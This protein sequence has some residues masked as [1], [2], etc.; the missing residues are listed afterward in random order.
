[1]QKVS[2]DVKRLVS[3]EDDNEDTTEKYGIIS[4][5]QLRNLQTYYTQQTM[6]KT[7]PRHVKTIFPEPEPE[8]EIKPKKSVRE[9]H[10]METENP[11]HTSI[12][13]V[14]QDTEES[15]TYSVKTESGV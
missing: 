12:V 4:E 15:D 8:P 13:R 1:M 7:K 6:E 2:R 10:V 9:F 14:Q 11:H 3:K 5:N